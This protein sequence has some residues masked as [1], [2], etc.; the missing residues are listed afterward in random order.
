MSNFWTYKIVLDDEN[1]KTLFLQRATW[2][3]ILLTWLGVQSLLGR[4]QP[5]WMYCSLCQIMNSMSKDHQG[6]GLKSLY[7]TLTSYEFPVPCLSYSTH[8]QTYCCI[9]NCLCVPRKYPLRHFGVQSVILWAYPSLWSELKGLQLPWPAGW[10]LNRR[11]HP[12][13]GRSSELTL[14]FPMLQWQPPLL[15]LLPEPQQVSH[16]P[17]WEAFQN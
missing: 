8:F 9:S 11:G 7:I 1:V 3:H 17:N 2:Q 4:I 16:C 12:L 6:E 15:T 13:I 10:W 14:I 5:K